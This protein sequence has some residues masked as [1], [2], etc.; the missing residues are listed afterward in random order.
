MTKITIKEFVD[1]EILLCVS[2]LVYELTQSRKCSL[3]KQIYNCIDEEVAIE[4]WTGSIDYEEAEN[5]IEEGD[6]LYFTKGYWGVWSKEKG[7]HI[8]DPV[9]N[10]KE[11]AITE[12]FDYDL[13]TFRSEIYEHW[14]VTSWLANKLEALD[15][16]V[17]RDFYGLTI[18][19]RPC[20]GQALYCDY[21]IQRIYSD[22]I[23]KTNG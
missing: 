10:S 17:V 9:H 14:I 2:S 3:C 13:D 21:V 11:D 4:L 15:E 8:V 5:E 22:L 20:T 18:Y 7:Y 12:Y 16:K 23:S 19:C 1:R 6:E